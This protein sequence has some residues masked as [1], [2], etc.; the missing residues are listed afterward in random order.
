MVAVPVPLR[1]VGLFAPFKPASVEETSVDAGFIADLT[2]KVL[3]FNGVITGGAVASIMCLPYSNVGDRVLESLKTHSLVEIRGGTGPLA[4]G[5][6]YALTDKGM[7]KVRE[8]LER[9][10]YAGP[11]PVAFDDYCAAVAH[12]SIKDVVV[13]RDNVN[14]AFA[15]M[16]LRQ[17]VIDQLGPAINSGKSVFLFDPPG[18]SKTTAAEVA[19]KSLD[20]HLYR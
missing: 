9:S 15:R 2:L 7:E 4:L 12:Q 8:L 1:N 11:C 3:Y 10:Q 5:Y 18:D 19:S 6:R 14:R 13:S 20:G 17:R 16:V